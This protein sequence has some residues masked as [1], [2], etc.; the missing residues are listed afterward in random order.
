MRKLKQNNLNDH[1]YL[2]H[3]FF[4][5]SRKGAKNYKHYYS[6]DNREQ[7]TRKSIKNLNSN[8]VN[9]DTTDELINL[10]CNQLNQKK[11]IRKAYA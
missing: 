7:I 9:I 4:V 2:Y 10:G 5:C 6:T 11:K 8:S 3:C 1:Y